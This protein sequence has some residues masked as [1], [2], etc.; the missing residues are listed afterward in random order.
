MGGRAPPRG[1]KAPGI[2]AGKRLKY[3]ENSAISGGMKY[4]IRHFAAFCACSAQFAASFAADSP[5][6]GLSDYRNIMGLC[7]MR[8][9]P[10]DSLA[11]AR[12][13]GHTHV[14][15]CHGMEN[16]PLAEGM[17][18]YFNDPEFSLRRLALDFNRKYSEKEIDRIQKSYVVASPE[19]AF[20]ENM[21]TSWYEPPNFRNLTLDFQQQKVIDDT[22][23]MA[24][25]KLKSIESRRPGF[26][27]AGFSWDEP[28]AS[29]NFRLPPKLDVADVHK[30]QGRNVT[31]A[32]WT[33]G[34][35]SN[36]FPG[37]THEYATYSEGKL[38]YYDALRREGLKLN[39]DF[40]LIAEPYGIYE[41]WI[42]TVPPELAEKME[43][44]GRGGYKFDFLMQEKSGDAFVS[45]PRIAGAGYGPDRTASST[46]NISDTERMLA[47]SSAAA[48]RGAWTMWYGRAGG[49]INAPNYKFIREIPARLKLLK[50]VPTW[51]NLNVTPV[52]ERRYD[53]EKMS[54]DSPTAHM[55][56]DCVWGKHPRDDKV[57]VVF[58]S[59]N[60]E[61]RLPAGR[62]V[63][64]IYLAD[65][66]FREVMDLPARDREAKIA[67][68]IEVV[69]G[70]IRILS[71]DLI[72][73]G[74]V[75]RLKSAGGK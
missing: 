12:Q 47:E 41:N 55:G 17:Y 15:Y 19:K 58:L 23:R 62:E 53:A 13:M 72:N 25:D 28:K 38:A 71:N 74:I 75:V 35:F 4:Y 57:F 61:A 48:A 22:V 36:P 1:G 34:D 27:V 59:P 8:D 68:R 6:F 16:S 26:R 42:G 70:A 73:E 10:E 64:G 2:S 20:P 21:A 3:S 32:H 50:A 37:C 60:A 66:L 30:A 52:P 45:D 67:P 43:R 14:I 29:G 40:K 39:P 65:G 18:F 44:L 49:T 24:A 54:Y 11:Y 69:G 46:P 56:A 7:W 51:E 33:G 5:K 9:S 31:L 63:E